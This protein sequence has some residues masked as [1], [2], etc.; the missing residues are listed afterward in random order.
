[1]EVE[2]YGVPFVVLERQ[3]R[4]RLQNLGIPVDARM[5]TA[6]TM[7]VIPDVLVQ[8]RARGK[9]N[10]HKLGLRNHYDQILRSE[11]GD[12]PIEVEPR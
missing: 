2:Q 4:E 9:V 3:V 1:M 8:L 7:K 6:V 5:V 11:D 10:V 12:A